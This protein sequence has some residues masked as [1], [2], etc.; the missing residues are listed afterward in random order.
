MTIVGCV[1]FSSPSPHVLKVETSKSYCH[2][3]IAIMI[4]PLNPWVRSLV[5]YSELSGSSFFWMEKYTGKAFVMGEEGSTSLR[6]RNN[7]K[8]HLGHCCL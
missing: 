4:I 7:N 1:L 6:T 8:T 3:V 2:V 5:F